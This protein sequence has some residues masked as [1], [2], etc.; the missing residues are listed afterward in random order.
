M[1]NVVSGADVAFAVPAL[2]ILAAI[3]NDRRLSEGVH[4]FSSGSIAHFSY[5][6][7]GIKTQLEP[8]S[9]D[10]GQIIVYNFITAL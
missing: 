5:G 7:L 2:F 9:M 3:R 6:S 4:R 8:P 10:G 1:F